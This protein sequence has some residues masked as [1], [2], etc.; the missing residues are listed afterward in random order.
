MLHRCSLEELALTLGFPE[1]Q[2]SALYT[3][4]AACYFPWC[5]MW[6]KIKGG[7][8]ALRMTESMDDLGRQ[9]HIL[10]LASQFLIRWSKN[11]PGFASGRGCSVHSWWCT[12]LGSWRLSG[13]LSAPIY[14]ATAWIPSA[15][16]SPH[17]PCCWLT[18]PFKISS[19]RG[20]HN[21]LIRFGG[22]RMLFFPRVVQ[23][24]WMYVGQLDSLSIRGLRVLNMQEMAALSMSPS[25]QF[26][27]HNVCF[28]SGVERNDCFRFAFLL[29]TTEIP[30]YVL[31]KC[32]F[33]QFQL[34]SGEGCE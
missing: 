31:S 24:V 9:L 14:Q 4:V 27:S 22:F 8:Q 13:I 5:G 21:C 2:I 6:P 33:S 12:L 19:R 34:L 25:P 30:H 11:N 10:L 20:R 16:S 18:M 7:S 28:C 26:A 3:G 29:R 15:I 17:P 1:S 32:G 23:I